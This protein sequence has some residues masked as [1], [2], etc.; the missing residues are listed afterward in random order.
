[1]IW[2]VAEW[3]RRWRDMIVWWWWRWVGIRLM[4]SLAQR[5]LLPL[6]VLVKYVDGVL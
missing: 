3:Q 4:L 2:D 1:M 5:Q 6:L